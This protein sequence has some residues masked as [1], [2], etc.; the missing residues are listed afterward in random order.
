MPAECT[1]APVT[2]INAKKQIIK[3]EEE[4]AAVDQE[5]E[6]FNQMMVRNTAD[7][8]D[9]LVQENMEKRTTRHREESEYNRSREDV[10]DS[11]GNTSRNQSNKFS[12]SSSKF[13][14]EK[15]Q[16]EIYKNI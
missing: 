16:L 9:R 3:K 8:M 4:K 10:M 5:T 2:N 1:F 6:M 12:P 7:E 15:S 14:T 11:A 13:Q